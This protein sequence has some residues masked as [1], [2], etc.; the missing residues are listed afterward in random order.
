M[1]DSK[2]IE[3][4][5]PEDVPPDWAN[6]LMKWALKTPGIQAMVGQSVALLT[7][8]GRKTGKSYTIPVSYY[9]E[10]DTVT[11]ISKRV[12]TWWRNFQAPADVE[13]RLAGK[14]YAGTARIRSD[15]EE[16]LDFMTDYLAKRPIDAKAYGLG[17]D[18]IV[19]D[20]IARI[21]PHIVVIDIELTPV[22]ETV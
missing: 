13:L 18:E 4:Q 11:V 15:D 16:T 10:G 8:T 20:E 14:M 9:R 21:I 19:R 17:K 3:V 1:T 7:F 12:R 6:S 2:T 5:L 22:P